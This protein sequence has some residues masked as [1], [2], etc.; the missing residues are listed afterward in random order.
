MGILESFGTGTPA[1]RNLALGAISR[2]VADDVYAI[3]PSFT[4]EHEFGPMAFEHAADAAEG[5]S[6]LVAFDEQGSPWVAAWAGVAMDGGPPD[7]PAGGSLAGTYP[8]PSIAA[9]AITGTEVAAANKDGAVG[10][11]SMRTLGTGA[12]Q[13]TPGDDSR[14]SN[15]RAPNGSAG[16]DLTG[17]YPN[18]T[19]K[20]SV[21]LTGDPTAPTPTAGDNDTS[22][23]TTAFVTTAT[24]TA[25]SGLAT[26]AS[27]TFTGDPKAP[28]PASGDADTSIATTAF[29]DSIAV[30]LGSLVPYAGAGDPSARWFLADG[31]AMS[32][33]TYAALYAVLGST[34]GAGLPGTT[35]NLP[36]LR[37]RVPVGP[38][39]MGTAQGAAS[40]M[41]TGNARGNTG[42]AETKA[43]ATGELPSHSHPATSAS[44]ALSNNSAQVASGLAFAAVNAV[45]A[46]TGTTGSGTAFN[47]MP[48]Y[49]VLNYIIRVL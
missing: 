4:R 22:I 47:K 12:L 38:D 42:G 33:T 29:V 11:P 19:I 41:A 36:D 14:L 31:R 28:T 37:G 32:Q 7:G 9:G 21:A 26:L 13:A 18:P 16:G 25:T 10:V 34:Y 48:P 3:V 43:L 5:D 45:A 40:R 6:I 20:A 2:I 39:N 23:A 46:A 8:N 27:P 35:F 44:F 30:P 1:S 15:S 49:V 17:T 24:S